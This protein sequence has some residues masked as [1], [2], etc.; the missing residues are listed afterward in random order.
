[1]CRFFS[2]ASG[3]KKFVC[4]SLFNHVFLCVLIVTITSSDAECD[5]RP[6]LR[7]AGAQRGA[8]KADRSPRGKTGLHKQQS[9]GSA[10]PAL[11]SHTAAT[12]TP[13][14]RA[15]PARIHLH[16]TLLAD[17]RTLLGVI[18]APTEITFYRTTH[19][20]R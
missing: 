4:V 10:W 14:G 1:M 13:A 7:A 2:H 9:A 6:G 8:G 12:A 19:V 3:H 18:R 15:D 17:L 5:V 11:T 16:E 20:L